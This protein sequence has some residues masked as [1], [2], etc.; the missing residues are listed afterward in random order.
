MA[1]RSAVNRLVPGSS[2]GRG[3]CCSRTSHNSI[4]SWTN[5]QNMPELP[6]VETRVK[7]L[8]S[9][10]INRKITEV[11]L[12]WPR[13]IHT[14]SPVEFKQRIIGQQIKQLNRRGKFL[15]FTLEAEFLIIHL[16]MSGDLYVTNSDNTID[17]HAHTTITFDNSSELRFSDVRKFGRIYL[18]KSTK[19]ITSKLGPEPLS[20]TF[21]KSILFNKLNS[22]K[23][24]IKPLLLD[25]HFL[26]GM[27][28]IYTDEALHLAKI[29][30]ARQ[31][32]T[33]S[34]NESTSL[35]RSIRQVL[36]DG[37]KNNGASIDWVYK[38]GNQ[39]NYFKVYGKNNQKCITCKELI[40]KITISQRGTHICP[41]CQKL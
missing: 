35:W 32:N 33:L 12:G 14:P 26:A 39:Q 3:V 11:H 25:Q 2:P 15:I 4:S 19:Q 24:M 40:L 41:N 20:K 34:L 13:H 9:P 27:G 23:R 31:S 8:R 5:T 38:G 36:R 6:E 17:Q 1:E 7:Q 29:H 28:N 30:P 18:M 22:H 21:T 16:R 37:I 10:C